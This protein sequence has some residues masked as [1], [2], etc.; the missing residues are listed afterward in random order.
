MK[1]FT[2]ILAS[3]ALFATGLAAP[4]SEA[5]SV[6]SLEERAPIVTCRPKL[7]GREKPFKVDVATAQAQARK[8]GLTTGKSGDPHRYFAGDHIRWGVNNC[9]KADA[10]LWE[11]PIYWVGKNAEWAKDVKT[12]QQKGGPTPIRVVYANSRGAVQYCGVM[13]HSKVDKN[14]QGKEFFEKCD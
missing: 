5:T 9:D 14:N 4:A 8:A 2:A 1:A 3:A 7:D 12:S 13:T 11:Y 10:I 6:N